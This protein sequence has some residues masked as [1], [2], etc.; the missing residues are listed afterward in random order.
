MKDDIES[1]DSYYV[2]EIKTLK[3]ILDHV[4]Q[5]KCIVFIDEILRGTNEKERVMMLK[6]FYSFYF[7]Q[8]H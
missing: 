2:K 8:I 6:L 4:K 1:G 3:T 7:H 5:Q